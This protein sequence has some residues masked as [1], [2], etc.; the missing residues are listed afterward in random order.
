M[1]AICLLGATDLR[2]RVVTEVDTRFLGVLQG[3]LD[4]EVPGTGVVRGRVAGGGFSVYDAADCDKAMV[5][6]ERAGHN[7]FNSVWAGADD[8][9]LDPAD[10]DRLLTEADH[11]ALAAEYIGG[12]FRWRLFGDTEPRG[13]FD[14]TRTNSRGAEV[15]LQWSFGSVRKVF[16]DMDPLHPAV[17]V[18]T[19]GD[20]AIER[21]HLV[22]IDG[23]SLREET[24]HTASVLVVV[25]PS[26]PS[27]SAPYT[28]SELAVELGA[29]NW[30]DYD[31]FTFRVGTACDL[32]DE[33]AIA[34]GVLPD[35]TI[36]FQGL[37]G[38]TV[39]SASEISSSLVPRRPVF[40]RV[41][42]LDES[43]ENCTALRLE[44]VSVPISRVMS[45]GPPVIESFSI[46][47][48]PGFP[49]PLF[50]TS[51]QLIRN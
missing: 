42:H 29:I 40:H 43:F 11:Q 37:E 6:I 4:G 39:V 48:A 20:A 32:T 7:R 22:E 51:F 50:F 15:S 19:L 31:A 34:A 45:V 21:L 26:S 25:P 1:E 9:L 46:S 10:L 28:L 30:A 27:A 24:N 18:R 16:D 14:G 47:P 23:R 36:T 35:F 33:A 41:R 49:Q 2:G 17:G 44:T 3:G 12:L 38:S 13:L 8:P 5:F